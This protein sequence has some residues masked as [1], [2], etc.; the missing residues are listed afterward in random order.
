MSE[1]ALT[2]NRVLLKIDGQTIGFVQE[3]TITDQV[4]IQRLFGL[5]DFEPAEL[6][7]GD[8]TYTITGS[9]YM[10]SAGALRALGLIP[11]SK[12]WL[13][14][15]G[16]SLEVIDQKGGAT[17]EHYS[18]CRFESHTRKYGKH[19]IIGE[20]FRLIARVKGAIVLPR[21]PE[22][23]HTDALVGK[24]TLLPEAGRVKP[25]PPLSSQYSLMNNSTETKAV[26]D[27]KYSLGAGKLGVG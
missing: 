25:P 17:L 9:K 4:E 13:S 16:L 21:P 18:D 11:E 7:P 19:T 26:L 15:P 1:R 22:I 10:V 23:S 14:A 12:D 5:G 8:V 2:G 3:V 27:S 6:V 24:Y 20:D